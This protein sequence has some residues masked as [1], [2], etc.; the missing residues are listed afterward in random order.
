MKKN[1]KNCRDSHDI[2]LYLQHLWHTG[3]KRDNY[4]T[5]YKDEGLSLLHTDKSGVR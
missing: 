4:I 3:T 5:I 2:S 1:D